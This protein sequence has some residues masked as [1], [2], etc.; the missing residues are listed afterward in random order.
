MLQAIAYI[1]VSTVEQA[2]EGVSLKA[3][4]KLIRD[5]ARFRKLKIV[6]VIVDAGISA[7][8]P[9]QERDGGKNLF[10]LAETDHV[11][12]VIAYKLDRLFRDAADCLTVTK[13]WDEL[14]VD[15]HL[16]DLGGQP[17]D[18]STAMGR[19]FLTIMAGVAEMERNM[20][21]ERTKAALA[22]LKAEGKRTGSIPYG[23]ML[24]PDNKTLLK[25]PDEQKVIR[26]ARRLRKQGKSFRKVAK[27]LAEKGH[28]SRTGAVF[29]PQQISRMLN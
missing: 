27:A 20:I 11:R 22:H 13:R 1:R 25:E 16:V 5:Y 9:L 26:L 28:R 21:R 29:H 17:V 12:A 24:A 18:T 15:L 3:Q 2:T 23:S 19:F 10:E 14:D 7:G 8:K 6:E 4:R